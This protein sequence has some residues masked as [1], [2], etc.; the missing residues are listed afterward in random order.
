MAYPIQDTAAYPWSSVV[1][2]VAYYPDGRAAAGSGVVVGPNDVL[3]AAHVISEPGYESGPVAVVV[4]P[5]ATDGAAGPVAPFGSFQAL[6]GDYFA[7][8]PDGDGFVYPAET[9][10]DLAVLGFAEP[11]ASITGAMAMDPG[12]AAGPANVSG[13]PAS[14]GTTTLA[15]A[16]A[17]VAPFAPGALDISGFGVEPGFSGGP[18]WYDSGFGP[19]VVGVVSTGLGAADLGNDYYGTVLGWMAANDAL[20]GTAVAEAVP[21]LPAD[22]PPP[23]ASPADLPVSPP[24]LPVVSTDFGWA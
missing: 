19:Q 5:G 14:L 6:Q 2:V 11:I 23:E 9:A 13:Y 18:V 15:N 4:T 10:Y 21:P 12:F 20:M 8:D 22:L 7:I 17:E 24:A 1:R 16:E 3:T